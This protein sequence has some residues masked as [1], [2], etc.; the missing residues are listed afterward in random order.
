MGSGLMSL[1]DLAI[2]DMV[3][4]HLNPGKKSI[5]RKKSQICLTG[6]VDDAYGDDDDYR[7]K[8]AKCRSHD[9]IF[10]EYRVGGKESMIYLK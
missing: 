1:G 8:L 10:G 4:Q 5:F 7:N 9:A 2:L 3:L 6:G